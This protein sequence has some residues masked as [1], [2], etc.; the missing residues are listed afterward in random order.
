MRHG[1]KLCKLLNDPY[2]AAH[3]EGVLSCVKARLR[4]K[5]VQRHSVGGAHTHTCVHTL[6]RLSVGCCHSFSGWMHMNSSN[7]SKTLD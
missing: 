4:V 1:R 6:V 2:D 7:S 5:R 3:C